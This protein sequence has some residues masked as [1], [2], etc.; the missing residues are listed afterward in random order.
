MTCHP[1]WHGKIMGKNRGVHGKI[2]ENPLSIE[3]L[4]ENKSSINGKSTIDGG[5]YGPL[6]MGIEMEKW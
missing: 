4:E 5:C 1:T 2:E 3:V 6:S